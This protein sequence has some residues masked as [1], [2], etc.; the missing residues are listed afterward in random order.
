M[1]IADP[2]LALGLMSGTSCDGIDAALLTTDGRAHV[3]FGPVLTNPYPADFRQRLRRI[4]GGR[5]PVDEVDMELTR[6][7]AESVG[8]LLLAAGIEPSAVR[9]L[10]FH[11]QTVLHEPEKGRTWQIGDDHGLC[12]PVVLHAGC[13]T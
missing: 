13:V 4:L 7:H 2:V 8:R 9:V 1:I 6:R 10:G 5:G 12:H 3:A 11:G